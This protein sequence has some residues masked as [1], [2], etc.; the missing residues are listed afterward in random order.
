LRIRELHAA[1]RSGEGNFEE[2][3]RKPFMARTLP[4]ETVREILSQALAEAKGCYSEAL[5]LLGIPESDYHPTMTFLKRHGCFID[6]RPF[7]KA[8]Q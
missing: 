7:R 3:V 4:C 5:G 2:L 8:P 6:F 1:L